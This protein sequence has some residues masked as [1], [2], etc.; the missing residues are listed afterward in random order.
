M[1]RLIIEAGIMHG[2][3]VGANIGKERPGRAREKW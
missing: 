3:A 2:S 1:T